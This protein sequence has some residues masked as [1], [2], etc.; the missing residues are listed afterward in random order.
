MFCS[1][2]RDLNDHA[3]TAVDTDIPMRLEPLDERSVW[4]GDELK[5]DDKWSHQIT[6]REL[7]E[8]LAATEQVHAAG[9]KVGDFGQEDFPLPTLGPQIKRLVDE[10]ENGRGVALL[11][12]FP[13]GEMSE[14]KAAPRPTGASVFTPV[15]SSPKT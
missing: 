13:V 14:D 4:L 3:S 1:K 2:G 9:L 12:G 15:I 8:L 10:V 5:R 7:Q 6:A 11:K